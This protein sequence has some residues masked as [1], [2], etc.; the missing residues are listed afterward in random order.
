VSRDL[1]YSRSTGAGPL[2]PSILLPSIKQG[3]ARAAFLTCNSLT[4]NVCCSVI[5]DSKLGKKELAANSRSTS[6]VR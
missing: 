6:R 5:L 2:A 1:F 3:G 4:L